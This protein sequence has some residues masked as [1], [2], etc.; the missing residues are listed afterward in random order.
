M[1]TARAV[2]DST[3]SRKSQRDGSTVGLGIADTSARLKESV[4]T[5]KCST[6]RARKGPLLVG[7]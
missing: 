7:L 2:E 1:T 6:K 5:Q 3:T 4:H